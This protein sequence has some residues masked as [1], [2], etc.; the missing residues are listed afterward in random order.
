M[1]RRDKCVGDLRAAH[2]AAA[3]AG[4]RREERLNVYRKTERREAIA[5]LTNA[6]FTVTAL[7]IQELQQLGARRIEEVRQQVNVPYIFD[8]RDLDTGNQ[9][10][11]VSVGSPFS[12]GQAGAGVVIRDADRAQ[13]GPGRTR[14]QGRRRQ[15]TVGGSRVKMKIDQESAAGARRG[16]RFARRG[17]E[18]RTL[19]WRRTSDRYSRIRSSGCARSSSA[20]SRKIRPF[21][22][23][24]LVPVSLEE[25]MGSA[26]ALD[27]N[28][29]CLAI[30]DAVG[31]PIGRG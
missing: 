24:E 17:G 15:K 6:L 8:R 28:H 7:R 11:A 20:N 27:A 5:D 21:R 1:S 31:E 9:S 29:E 13:S 10:Q 22:V 4:R 3:P 19:R 16:R 23:L 30:V 12:F 25:A 14:D 26:L 18:R 2:R